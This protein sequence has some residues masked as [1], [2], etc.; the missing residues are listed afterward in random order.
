[1][2]KVIEELV[3]DA[4]KGEYAVKVSDLL[5]WRENDPDKFSE[6][7]ELFA[8]GEGKGEP[9]SLEK[10]ETVT[11]PTPDEAYLVV[12]AFEAT[13]KKVYKTLHVNAT[14]S[15]R[16]E[17]IFPLA[18][19]RRIPVNPKDVKTLKK[20]RILTEQLIQSNLVDFGTI[21][22]TEPLEF[23]KQTFTTAN[24]VTKKDDL[25]TCIRKAQTMAFY[26]VDFSS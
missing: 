19:L 12:R 4:N 13:N 21:V 23:I 11:F 25:E 3:L 15:R 5:A 6:Y 1:M 10:G 2:S 16:G 17:L 22:V 14:S 26:K 18:I 20:D 9:F 24:K 7:E 8:I